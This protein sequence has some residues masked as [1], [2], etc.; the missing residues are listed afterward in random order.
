MQPLYPSSQPASQPARPHTPHMPPPQHAVAAA[1][2]LLNSCFPCPP[3]A[4]SA[5]GKL[6]YFEALLSVEEIRDEAHPAKQSGE[7]WKGGVAACLPAHARFTYLHSF[8]SCAAHWHCCAS[9][10]PGLAAHDLGAL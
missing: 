5:A 1:A 9:D 4:V 2:A 6:A 10:A 7:L 3:W 8:S